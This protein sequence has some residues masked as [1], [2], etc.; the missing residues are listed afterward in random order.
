MDGTMPFAGYIETPR[1]D[2]SVSNGVSTVTFRVRLLDKTVTSDVLS[3]HN[4]TDGSEYSNSTGKMLITPEWKEFK[5]YFADGTKNGYYQI[6]AAVGKIQVDDIVIVAGGLAIPKP[7]GATDY[8]DGGTSFTANWEAVEGASKYILNV[9]HNDAEGYAEYDLKNVEVSATSY[10]VSGLTAGVTYF[11]NVAA[12]D[13]DGIATAVSPWKTV[14]AEFGAPVLKP[15]TNVTATGY[16]ANWQPVEGATG[17]RVYNMMAHTATSAGEEFAL[18]DTDF[19]NITEGSLDSPKSGVDNGY[20]DE[21]LDKKEWQG[22]SINLAPGYFVLDNEFYSWYPEMASMFPPATMTSPSLN[23]SW[24]GGKTT[25]ELNGHATKKAGDAETALYV[26][27]AQMD[28]NNKLVTIPSTQQKIVLTGEDKDYKVTVEGGPKYGVL[29]FYVES[30]LTGK[31]FLNSLKVYENLSEGETQSLPVEFK[32]V[33]GNA[34]TSVDFV[35]EPLSGNESYAYMVC[36]VKKDGSNIETSPWSPLQTVANPSSG[37]NE[38][39][40][41]N[42]AYAYANGGKLTVVNP[43]GELVTVFDVYGRLV[44]AGSR[45]QIQSVELPASGLYIVRIGKVTVKVAK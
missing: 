17:Y 7:T 19:S 34:T 37:V 18:L 39:S 2:L 30:A 13:A 27:Y 5:S 43:Q 28:E 25:V 9:A 20:L 6:T 26:V 32:E 10:A 31:V 44:Y 15:A 45:D 41:K 1:T 40:A 35:T 16:T 42:A 36:A 29:Y 14:K 11:Y 22:S 4:V 23:F 33:E 21:Y 12:V 3:V 8:T 24:G 38:A